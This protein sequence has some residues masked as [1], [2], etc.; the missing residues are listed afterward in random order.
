MPVGI[1]Q[2]CILRW[3]PWRDREDR[4]SDLRSRGGEIDPWTGCGCIMTLGK[5]FTPD[6]D[7]LRYFMESLKVRWVRKGLRQVRGLCR[8][9][10]PVRVV[11]FGTGPTRLS[12]WSGLVVSVLNST[13]WIR[14][15]MS[16]PATRSP[17][18]SGPCQIP[19]HRPTDYVCDPTRP[20]PRSKSVH[21]EI[22]LTNLR[23]DNRQSP[24]TCRRPKRVAGLVWSGPHTHT[25]LTALFP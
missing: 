20:D 14:P 1:W 9:S 16:A 25:L 21:V 18:K 7:S 6:A 8:D 4:M 10:G 11:E 19:L 3:R 17:T 5:S 12:R 24:L 2:P 22:E 23:P 15:D 13:T